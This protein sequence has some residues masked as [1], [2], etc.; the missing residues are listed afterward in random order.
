MDKDTSV[1]IGVI[2]LCISACLE[3]VCLFLVRI[4]AHSKRSGRFSTMRMWLHVSASLE[5]TAFLV[6]HI[7]YHFLKTDF[8]VQD[9]CI[10]LRFIS[11][12]ASTMTNSWLFVIASFYLMLTIKPSRCF[13]FHSRFLSHCCTWTWTC[14]SCLMYL[15]LAFLLKEEFYIRYIHSCWKSNP[16]TIHM[17]LTYG[18]EFIPFLL[19]FLLLS[20]A[21][22]RIP[23]KREE[24][25]RFL[26]HSQYT[27]N[28]D[29]ITNTM[30]RYIILSSCL[31]FYYI[32]VTFRVLMIDNGSD[33]ILMAM[34]SGKGIMIGI[35][36]C[37]VSNDVISLICCH[38]YFQQLHRN[39][40]QASSRNENGQPGNTGSHELETVTYLSR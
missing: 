15:M 35:M 3:L 9:T 37:F 39:G 32:L 12:L 19:S 2:L 30:N 34:Q 20:F 17:F 8:K 26:H 14:V 13:T 31:L 27:I 28:I 4:L 38:R 22:Y 23:M 29:C 25:Q 11:S 40:L 1:I 33:I 7:K 21:R 24:L 16:G 10:V 36:T 6:F 5:Q 18:N